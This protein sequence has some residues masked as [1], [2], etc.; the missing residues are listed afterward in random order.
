MMPKHVKPSPQRTAVQPDAD[1]MPVAGCTEGVFVGFVPP[2]ELVG[3]AALATGLVDEKGEE[4]ESD[5][6]PAPGEVVAGLV[7][8]DPVRVA[9]L[10]NPGDPRFPDLQKAKLQPAGLA[11]RPAEPAVKA[12]VRRR[13]EDPRFALLNP[14]LPMQRHKGREGFG[15]LLRALYPLDSERAV[16]LRAER[17][18]LIQQLA[19]AMGL[20]GV[21][22]A[23][24]PLAINVVLVGF[25]I[26]VAGLQAYVFA[27]LTCI[28][29]HDAVHLH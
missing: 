1:Q 8:I 4:N 25:E 16:R 12:P 18:A 29:L 15:N 28:Y 20:I 13:S 26:L 11:G 3:E 27:V 23:V 14:A 7:V 2:K 17:S 6:V 22:A 5:A 24:I 10:V 21:A 9:E 19:A